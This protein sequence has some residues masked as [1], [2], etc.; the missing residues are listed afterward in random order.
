MVGS[1]KYITDIYNDEPGIIFKA[2]PE[3]LKND[4]RLN[5][6]WANVF[7]FRS[8]HVLCGQRIVVEYIVAV[9]FA[10]KPCEHNLKK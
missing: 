8:N 2:T 6:A 9:L 5:D 3:L 4:G 7:R 10:N 1:F